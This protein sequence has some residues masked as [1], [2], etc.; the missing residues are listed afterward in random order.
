MLTTE[1]VHDN[2]Q[3]IVR[4]ILLIKGASFPAGWEY[5]D[6]QEYYGERLK[7]KNNINIFLKGKNKR[8]GYLLA[9]PHN[10]AIIELKNDDP[11][12]Q[13]DALRYYIETVSI[14]PGYRNKN[15]FSTLLKTLKQE[16]EKRRVQDISLHAR[17]VNDFSMIIQKKLKVT[18]LRQI[19]SW[20]YCNNEEPV[21]YIE[22]TV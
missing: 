22:A 4:E 8:I 10:K 1:V 20:K 5:G 16:L 7:N 14:Y 11:L 12:M 17:V 15:G 2:D 6:A 19:A 13:E 21:D 9:I 18:H 3:N